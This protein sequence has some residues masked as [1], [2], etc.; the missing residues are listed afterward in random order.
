MEV[1]L[2]A[3]SKPAADPLELVKAEIAGFCFEAVD[4]AEAQVVGSLCVGCGVFYADAVVIYEAA[5][6]G[7][8]GPRATGVA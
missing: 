4:Q 3:D 2:D 5:F 8:P 1:A 6:V 7:V